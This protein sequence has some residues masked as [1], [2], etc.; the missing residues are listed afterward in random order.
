MGEA[1]N[2]KPETLNPKPHKPLSPKPLTLMPGAY[3]RTSHAL[4]WVHGMKVPRATR[5]NA[6][7]FFFF[8]WGWGGGGG[9]GRCCGFRV[10]ALGSKAVR[11]RLYRLEGLGCRVSASGFRV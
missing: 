8:L 3:L 7:S 4:E 6:A 1:L 10:L 2:P 9:G 11:F 5:R